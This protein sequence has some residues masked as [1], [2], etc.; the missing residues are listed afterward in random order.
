MIVDV[1]SIVF[2]DIMV[3]LSGIYTYWYYIMVNLLVL[4]HVYLVVVVF[5]NHCIPTVLVYV[6]VY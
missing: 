5:L 6:V 2:C 1:V 4:Y 3:K